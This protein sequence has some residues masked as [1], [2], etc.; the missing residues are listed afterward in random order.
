MTRD[1]TPAAV[2]RTIVLVDVE[3]FGKR[4]TNPRQ[5]AV[6][7]GMYR[8]LRR[9][10]D[11]AGIPW[12]DCRHEDRG[13]G[14][15]VLAP[16]DLP[17]GPF[18][19]ALPAALARALNEH[20]AGRPADE[21]IRL[22]LALHAGEV[23]YD[24]QGVTGAAVVLAFRLL[25]ARPLKVAL[26]DSP[27]VLAMITSSWFYEEVVRNGTS[28]DPATYRRVPVA[29]KEVDTVGWVAL[30]DHPYLPDHRRALT[31]EPLAVVEA[32]STPQQLPA[33]TRHFVGRTEELKH[34]DDLVVETDPGG[35]VLISAIGGTPG[36]GK[37]TLAV[38]WARRV[39]ERFPD[40]QLYVNLRGFDPTGE[41][42]RPEEA[43]RG[44][45]DALGVPPERV[46]ASPDAQAALYR[47]VV[48][49][50][51]VLVVLDNARDE[52]QVRPLLPGVASCLALVTSRNRMT[53][54][55]AAEGAHSVDLDVLDVDD[56]AML[57]RRYLGAERVAAEPG[58]MAELITRC[59]RLPL[60]LAIV[61]A[62]ATANP[63]FPL[64]VLARELRE[65][66]GRLDALDAGAP[67]TSVRV[68]FSWSY[69][70]LG[71]AAARMFRRLGLAPGPDIGTHAAAHLLAVPVTVARALLAELTRAHLLDE[72]RPGR[73]RCHD[74]L[75]AYAAELAAAEDTGPERRAGITRLLD[76]Y[77]TTATRAMA[78]VTPHEAGHLPPADRTTGPALDDYDAAMAWLDV[79]RPN[80]TA[81]AHVAGT[82]WPAHASRLSRALLRYLDL[83][84][85]H[86]DAKSVHQDALDAA[87]RTGDRAAQAHALT[88]LATVAWRLGRHDEALGLFGQVL[89]AWTETGHAAARGRTLALMGGVCWQLGRYRE[90]MT[91]YAPAL[92]LSRTIGDAVAEGQTLA[93]MGNVSWWLGDYGQAVEHYRAAL[94]LARRSG[95]RNAEAHALTGLANVSLRVGR[96]ERALDEYHWALAMCRMTGEQKIRSYALAGLGYVHWRLGRHAEAADQHRRV[97]ALAR[98]LGDPIVESY[99][100]AGLG[101]VYATLGRF[102]EGAQR[103]R[104]ALAV[105]RRTGDRGFEAAVLNALGEVAAATG[106]WSA[107]TEHH[108][109][110]LAIADELGNRFEQANAWRGLASVAHHEGRR[111]DASGWWRR[112]EAVYR[113]LG[114]PEAREPPEPLRLAGH[115]GD[116]SRT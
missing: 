83:R 102:D 79:E 15:F 86:L 80:L 55:I 63:D 61:A 105:C 77:V 96:Y 40:G 4:R 110:A 42:M 37:T 50:R 7:D 68:V 88:G 44:F 27:G 65:E 101:F 99:A 103:H 32:G 46:P 73:Y 3:G 23:S 54:L 111:D 104:E 60:A 97:L 6:R 62:K 90:A 51:R 53:G 108:R 45:L 22:R 10:F 58:A 39:A 18:A 1:A 31:D 95:D 84:S 24:E 78:V 20:N 49:G 57:L 12:D 69:R 21:R 100:L 115:D 85:H 116:D 114:V 14:V 19:D 106:E 30:P 91:H 94:D 81:V 107:A 13:D 16:A 35:P 82:D 89:D 113:E 26:A 74:L 98:E 2:H 43:L 33:H 67:G 47:T 28:V 52:T 76:H 41:P 72:H 71:P 8:A 64:T 75:R 5:L 34:L 93:G 87:R 59:E 109:R 56:A 17:K 36:I 112:A 38:H 25:D 29:V 48:S 70:A 92:A 9:A 11:L 66:E